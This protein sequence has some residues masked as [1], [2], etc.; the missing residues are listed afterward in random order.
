VID[1]MGTWTWWRKASCSSKTTWMQLLKAGLGVNQVAGVPP[2]SRSAFVGEIGLTGRVHAGS[3]MGGRLAAARTAGLTT[4]FCAGEPGS[5]LDGLQMVTVGHVA[6]ALVWAGFGGR[7][8]AK[9][10]RV[11]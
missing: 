6:D 5:T 1:Q 11:A 9:R 2:P 10:D 7:S 4:V 3:G 8:R